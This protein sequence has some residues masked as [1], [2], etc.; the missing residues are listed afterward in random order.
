MKYIIHE[1]HPDGMYNASSKAREDVF[2]ISEGAGYTPFTIPSKY[3]VQKEVWKKPLQL[4]TYTTN[5][6]AWMQALD[7][8]KPGD[9]LLIQYPLLNTVYHF[10]RFL[11]AAAVKGIMTVGLIHDMDSLRYTTENSTSMVVNRVRKED[12]TYLP[13]FSCVIAHNPTMKDILEKEYGLRH[14]ISLDAFDYLYADRHTL[15]FHAL[16][17]PVVIAGNLDSRKAGYLKELGNLN[18]RFNLY[19]SNFDENLKSANVEYIGKFKPELLV[20]ALH[21]S[22]GLV[23][24]GNSAQTCDSGFG[25]YLRCNNPHKMSLYIASEMPVI[26]WSQAAVADFVKKHDIGLVV[27]SLLDIEPALRGLDERD[28]QRMQ[29]NTAALAASIRKGGFLLKALDQLPFETAL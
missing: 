16:K 19:G 20:E 18:T 7:L 13:A 10:E 9:V 17:E 25:G 29:Q 3:G 14:V 2:E 5:L 4:V 8:F 23:W 27:D 15:W 1:G 12:S 24:D 26:V 21:G 28:Y 11:Q 22:F 6:N